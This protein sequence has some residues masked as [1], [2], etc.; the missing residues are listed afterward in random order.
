MFL[1]SVFCLGF[2]GCSLPTSNTHCLFTILKETSSNLY[3]LL[4]WD[5]LSIFLEFCGFAHV[6]S[7]QLLR[8]FSLVTTSAVLFPSLRPTTAFKNQKSRSSRYSIKCSKG[9][10][11]RPLQKDF[12]KPY[13]LVRQSRSS[14]ALVPGWAGLSTGVK[15]P[16]PCPQQRSAQLCSHGFTKPHHIC[17]IH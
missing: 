8:S 1:I 10:F 7:P 4:F 17:F 14:W 16:S 6:R 13:E 9:S 2:W 11:P 3:G 12:L 5:N 15:A